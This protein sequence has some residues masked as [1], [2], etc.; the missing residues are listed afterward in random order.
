MRSTIAGCVGLLLLAVTGVACS[1]DASTQ[2]TATVTTTLPTVA[3]TASPSGTLSQQ[4]CTEVAKLRTDLDDLKNINVLQSG[5]DAVKAKLTDIQEDLDAIKAAA[6]S[7]QDVDAFQ[8]ALQSLQT[9][10]A[11]LGSATPSGA[12]TEVATAA[13][14]AVLAGTTLVTRLQAGCPT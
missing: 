4:V 6:G 2:P 8:S 9:A 12:L 14:G 7:A 11:N 3:S 5:T 10:I 1:N 13:A